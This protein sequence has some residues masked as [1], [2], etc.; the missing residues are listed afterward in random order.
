MSAGTEP[1]G[2]VL[3][4]IPAKGGS[5][6][7]A[8][9]NVLPLGGKPLL[10]WAVDAALESGV[11]DSLVVSTE[12]EVGLHALSTLRGMGRE[13]GTL[14]IL[15]PTCPLRTA[16]DI[17]GAYRRYLDTGAESLMSVALCGERP[18]SALK[19]EGDMLSYW[20][21]EYQSSKPG[22]LPA[23]YRPNGAI[24]VLDVPAFERKKSYTAQ[25]LVGYLMPQERSVDVDTAVDLAVAEAMLSGK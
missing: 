12:D 20:F 24:H 19:L 9:K 3:G 17:R 15:L 16:E 14:V 11:M 22:G 21:P 4:L 1:K 5:Q 25:P 2:P 7:L 10:Q 6:R 13:Y 18:F 8:R 23:A